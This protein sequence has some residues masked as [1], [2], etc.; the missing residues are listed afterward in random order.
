MHKGSLKNKMICRFALNTSFVQD[1]V[2]EFTKQTVDPDSIVKDNRISWDFKVQV[3]FSDFCNKCVPSMSI[4]N[5]CGR[6]IN[7]MDDEVKTWKVIKRILD[8]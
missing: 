5:L 4:D 7:Y 2:Y 3:Y 8:V 6:C 1:N